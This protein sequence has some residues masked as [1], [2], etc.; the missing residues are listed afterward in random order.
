MHAPMPRSVSSLAVNAG[1]DA[2][3]GLQCGTTTTGT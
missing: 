1:C 3:C 2:S